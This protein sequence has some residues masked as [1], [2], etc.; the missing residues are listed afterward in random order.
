MSTPKY[1]KNAAG[2]FV[3]PHCTDYVCEKQNT[4]FYHMAEHEDVK[5]FNC[6]PCSTGFIQRSQWLKHLA[7]HHP[8]APHPEGV[9]NP[10]V[11]VAFH[12]PS[13]EREPMKTKAQLI[14]HYV[15][16]HCKEWIPSFT[17]GEPCT[18]CHRQFNSPGAYLHHAADCF[19]PRASEHHASIISRIK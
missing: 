9:V 2:E 1:T 16:S 7:H 3:C 4:M 18:E 19:L 5:P 15:R 14:V 13:C 10:Y 8:D 11:G 17:K 12:C 6:K